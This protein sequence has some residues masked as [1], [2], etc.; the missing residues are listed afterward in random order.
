MGNC[1]ILS[2]KKKFW[3]DSSGKAGR[4][5]QTII[6]NE[7]L[8]VTIMHENDKEK[9]AIILE[10]T[11]IFPIVLMT[12]MALLYMG[13]MK[14]QET[15]M[16]YQVQ[17]VASQGSLMAASPGY[18]KL[19]DNGNVL[20]AKDIDFSSFPSNIEEYYEAYHEDP[21]RL[22]REIFGCTWIGEAELESYGNKVL[23]TVTVLALG[24]FVNKQVRIERSFWGTTVV[25]QISYEVKTPAVL[26][27]FDLPKTLRWKQAAY[28][29][30]VNPAGFMRNTDLAADAIVLGCEKL[31]LK[32]GLDKIITFMNKVT[33]ILF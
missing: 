2:V 24:N 18:A 10:A 20:D 30:A 32:D 9:G 3:K 12:V 17:R 1:L 19:C 27:Y 16:L 31:G 22:Y 28:S 5:F 33:D 11:I 7:E 26:R 13:L 25:A 23:D 15:A 21:I 6:E 4:I 8:Q 29:K 14:L